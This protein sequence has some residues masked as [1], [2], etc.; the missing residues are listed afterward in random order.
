[1]VA[2][3]DGVLLPLQFS[4]S[5]LE[6]LRRRVAVPHYSRGVH[7]TSAPH[8]HTS[9]VET[10]AHKMHTNDKGGPAHQL[11]RAEN[12][13]TI[14]RQ[15][16]LWRRRQLCTARIM[17]VFLEDVVVIAGKHVCRSLGPKCRREGFLFMPH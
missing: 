6:G 9:G 8:V 14:L 12:F 17:A 4:S 16:F 5:V 7:A 1:M 10:L 2:G 13:G 3:R 15:L 11:E